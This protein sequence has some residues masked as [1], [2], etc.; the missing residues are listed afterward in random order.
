[1]L[2]SV[3]EQFD[4]GVNK[5]IRSYIRTCRN[6]FLKR[7]SVMLLIP[8]FCAMVHVGGNILGNIWDGFQWKWWA[9][10]L[11]PIP[12]EML[13]GYFYLPTERFL[14]PIE[15]LIYLIFI[16]NGLWIGW[17]FLGAIYI[18]MPLLRRVYS[19]L[20]N[21]KSKNEQTLSDIAEPVSR[22]TKTLVV[23]AVLLSTGT[24]IVNL[25]IYGPLLLSAVVGLSLVAFWS[26]FTENRKQ[27][28]VLCS[29]RES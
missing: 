3:A 11:F 14:N 4:Y 20:G 19:L 22:F 28:V 27:R 6:S 26:L 21:S 13:P 24:F 7:F 18:M 15:T 16:D 8:Y 17:L 9:Y 10:A 25:A 23:L 5:S 2:K 12:M 29:R 1:L